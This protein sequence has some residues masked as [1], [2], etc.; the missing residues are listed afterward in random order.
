[1]AT[2]FMD[3]D[4][5]AEILSKVAPAKATRIEEE[6]LLQK[7]LRISNDQYTAA[8]SR[9]IDGVSGRKQKSARSY[10]RPRGTRAG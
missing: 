3:E 8:L 5:I 10:I 1:M 4:E 2:R 6:R 7:H 9:I